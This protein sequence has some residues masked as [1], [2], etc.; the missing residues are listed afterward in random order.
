ME[1]QEIF[2]FLPIQVLHIQYTTT[3]GN[4]IQHLWTR[5]TLIKQRF[6][7]WFCKKKKIS[8]HDFTK[9]MWYFFLWVHTL[10]HGNNN[11]DSYRNL[12]SPKAQLFY[13]QY[14]KMAGSYWFLDQVLKLWYGGKMADANIVLLLLSATLSKP[15]HSPLPS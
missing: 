2:H 1:G 15:L 13:K 3:V 12:I 7:A 4:M 14:H 11:R 9:Q 5:N 10:I 8:L 6:F